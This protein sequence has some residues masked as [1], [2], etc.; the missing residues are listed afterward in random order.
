MH[1]HAHSRLCHDPAVAKPQAALCLDRLCV[2]LAIVFMGDELR[3][4]R[5]ADVALGIRIHAQVPIPCEGSGRGACRRY[6]GR[7]NH[8]I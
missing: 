1:A 5:L 8:G 3:V 4:D 7:A 2:R 6:R